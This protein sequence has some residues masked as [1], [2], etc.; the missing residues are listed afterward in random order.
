MIKFTV[1]ASADDKTPIEELAKRELGAREIKKCVII[2]KSI[3]ARK[4]N[5]VL[6]LYQVAAETDNDKMYIRSNVEPYQNDVCTL[7]NMLVGKK[8]DIRPIVVGSGPSGLFCAL[9]LATLGAKPL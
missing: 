1:T 6:V 7:E 9:V 3:D 5:N 8:T 2:K 4:K